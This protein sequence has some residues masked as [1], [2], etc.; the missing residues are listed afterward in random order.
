MDS[1]NIG[2]ITQSGAFGGS[3]L[4]LAG[5]QPKPLGFNKWAHVDNMVDVSNLEISSQKP[6]FLLKV[7]RTDLG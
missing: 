4:I 1:G 7:G 3:V 2:F 5:D 6:I